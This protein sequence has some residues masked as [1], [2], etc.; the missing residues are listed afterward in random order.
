M[1]EASVS[2]FTD[3]GLIIKQLQFGVIGTSRKEDEQRIPIHPEH[4]S[5]LPESIRRQLIFEEGYG[6][7]FN[8]SD[9]ELVAQSGGV[10]SRHSL[11]STIGNVILAKPTSEDFQELREGGI[12]WGYP[13]CVQQSS[14]T[15]IA[16]DRKQ[17]LIAFEDMFVWGPNGTIGRHTFYKNNHYCPNV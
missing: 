13:H 7:P 4:M 5:R 1:Y 8:I 14:H 12:L 16:I 6:K 3:K 15:Q 9:A 11:L 17:T 2:V 10:A